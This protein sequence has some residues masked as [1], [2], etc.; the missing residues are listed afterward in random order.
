MAIERVFQRYLYYSH[1]HTIKNAWDAFW[2][3]IHHCWNHS[4]PT[5]QT[6]K[7]GRLHVAMKSDLKPFNPCVSSGMLFWKSTERLTSW[8]GHTHTQ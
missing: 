6:L 4:L 3:G 1:Y 5:C 7:A 8:G 2:H